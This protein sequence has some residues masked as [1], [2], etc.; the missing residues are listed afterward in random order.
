MTT[1]TTIC[2]SPLDTPTFAVFGDGAYSYILNLNRLASRLPSLITM[3]CSQV[4]ALNPESSLW[5]L[6]SHLS[7]PLTHSPVAIVAVIGGFMAKFVV[8]YLSGDDCVDNVFEFD[9]FSMNGT[10]YHFSSLCWKQITTQNTTPDWRA[11]PDW[12]G[13]LLWLVLLASVHQPSSITYCVH[14]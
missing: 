3:E 14:Y 2:S 8:S 10:I 11:V 1:L 12:M 4:Q 7:Q 13:L 9:G 6:L 5:R